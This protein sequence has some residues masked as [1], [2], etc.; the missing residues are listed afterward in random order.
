MILERR[1]VSAE[2]G[3]RRVHAGLAVVVALM[4]WRRLTLPRLRMPSLRRARA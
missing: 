3:Q 1:D 4:Y 2:I